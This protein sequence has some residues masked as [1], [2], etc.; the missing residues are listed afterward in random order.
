M[1]KPKFFPSLFFLSTLTFFA[2]VSFVSAESAPQKVIDLAHNEIAAFGYDP[3]L[4][5]AVK[6]ENAKNKPIEQI[7]EID[8]KWIATAGVSDFMKSLIESDAGQHLVEIRASRPYIAEIFVMDNQGAIVAMS[9]KTSDYWQGDEAKWQKSFNNR[10]GAIFVD[11][12]K[13]DA[14]SQSY[15][16]QVSVPIKNGDEAIG[17]ITF[18]IDIDR[19]R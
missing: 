15:L 9:D 6:A 7:K 1:S 3:I 11:E 14:S 10:Q 17:A 16:V 12:V 18:G 13:F 4:V 2:F 5:A 8:V 19:V